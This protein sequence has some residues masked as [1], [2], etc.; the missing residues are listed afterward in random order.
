[1]KVGIYSNNA[2]V[3]T[4]LISMC[5]NC[6]CKVQKILK[7]SPGIFKGSDLIIIDLDNCDDSKD[8]LSDEIQN[9]PEIVFVGLSKDL[10]II[11]NYRGIMNV[12]RKP[13]SSSIFKRYKDFV[14]KRL[15]S[16]V[17]A[18]KE[19]DRIYDEFG[20]N[21]ADTF[22]N[23]KISKEERLDALRKTIKEQSNY[24]SEEVFL[25]KI[26]L[27]NI[28][29]ND[30]K[31]RP[32]EQIDI[33]KEIS[34]DAIVK[35]RIR[36]LKMMN[37]SNKDVDDKINELINVNIN[38]SINRPKMT[39]G[40][41][42]ILSK[43]RKQGQRANAFQERK[44]EMEAK[45]ASEKIPEKPLEKPPEK[46]VEEEKPKQ[47][48]EPPVVEKPAVE[49]EN[50]PKKPVLQKPML[51]NTDGPPL[52]QNI[53]LKKPMVSIGLDDNEDI[54]DV[55][56]QQERLEKSV[57]IP[58]IPSEPPRKPSGFARPQLL[59]NNE[60]P[61]EN[62]SKEKIV[63]KVETKKKIEQEVAEDPLLKLRE[64]KRKQL[65]EDK[66][67][68]IDEKLSRFS[69]NYDN[70]TTTSNNKRDVIIEDNEENGFGTSLVDRM[71]AQIGYTREHKTTKRETAYDIA[72]KKSKPPR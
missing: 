63:D 42:D 23:S 17:V 16:T 18:T 62:E 36:K 44:R 72:N 52:K 3:N 22:N 35:Y 8:I 67:K 10:D 57:G 58:K 49:P 15:E 29:F 14:L 12:E 7:Y 32:L 54:P 51:S 9:M 33:K 30:K 4:A 45:K 11:D 6:G 5:A 50:K 65:E 26:G 53:G 27:D 61:K 47:V 34:T 20:I 24:D 19:E 25:K 60:E 40:E 41:Q 64:K 68:E 55:K 48:V 38:V 21:L 56:S 13:F 59:L 46:P 28:E 39:S 69:H 37:L 66:K 1:M 43:L 2:Q 70:K 71:Q 31:K